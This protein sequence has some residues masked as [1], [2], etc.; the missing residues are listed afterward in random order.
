MPPQQGKMTNEFLKIEKMGILNDEEKWLLH[1]CA[2]VS[3]WAL[4]NI[5]TLT[6]LMVKVIYKQKTG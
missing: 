2:I 6:E 5:H 4:L 1:N 3:E